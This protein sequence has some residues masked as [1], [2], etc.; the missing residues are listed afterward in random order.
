[1]KKNAIIMV[2]FAIESRRARGTSA[3][4]AVREAALLRF[5][6]ILMTT[7]AAFL[8]ALP[9]AI[10]G[11]TG[12]ELRRSLGIAMV[13]G[14]ALSQLVTLFTTPVIYLWLDRIQARRAAVDRRGQRAHAAEVRGRRAAR[15]HV[16]WNLGASFCPLVLAPASAS[17]C[18][19]WRISGSSGRPGKGSL[20]QPSLDLS[21][22][23]TMR[24]L[25]AG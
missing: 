18:P 1:V 19:G 14:L 6:P 12:S 2:D 24:P 8:G 13:G 23:L 17:R 4:V 3:A 9:L 20:T 10:G 22:F 7:M 25:S 11:G 16:V 15:V 5:R 21:T